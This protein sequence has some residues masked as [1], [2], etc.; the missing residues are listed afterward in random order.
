MSD[1]ASESTPE[2]AAQWMAD[3]LRAHGFLEQETA[4]S[5]IERR[6]GDRFVYEKENGNP[7]IDR[8]GPISRPPGPIRRCR[9]QPP[10]TARST[11]T[12]SRTSPPT[13]H[14]WFQLSINAW[15]LVQKGRRN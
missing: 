13:S 4:V 6:F 5:E 14:S 15:R 7:P 9:P 8:K 10:A 11:N 2:E 1:D 3:E 12:R